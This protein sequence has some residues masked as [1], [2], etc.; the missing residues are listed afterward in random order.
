MDLLFKTLQDWTDKDF[1]NSE[2]NW[3]GRDASGNII[4]NKK[5]L[6]LFEAKDQE[7]GL[8]HKVHNEKACFDPELSITTTSDCTQKVKGTIEL[9]INFAGDAGFYEEKHG[10]EVRYYIDYDFYK[11]DN[12]G[13][14][15]K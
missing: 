2:L 4:D 14:G 3:D 12:F 1:G 6:V 7:K 10:F 15:V 13:K 5:V 9:L 8:Q 11:A